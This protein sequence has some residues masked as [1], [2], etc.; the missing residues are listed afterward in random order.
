[1]GLLGQWLGGTFDNVGTSNQV[2]VW[3]GPD[4]TYD[5]LAPAWNDSGLAAAIAA[6]GAGVQVKLYAG[7]DGRL[8]ITDTGSNV[9][10]ARVIQRISAAV[11]RIQL[12]V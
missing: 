4:S 5:L 9:A 6:A 2:G 1:M 12:L 8:C 7:T 11:L 3:M 10:V